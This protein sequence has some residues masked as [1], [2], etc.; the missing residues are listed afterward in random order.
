MIKNVVFTN[1][2]FMI[3]NDKTNEKN[4]GFRESNTGF[5]FPR[6]SGARLRTVARQLTVERGTGDANI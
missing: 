3:D 5:S 4:E 6:F 2:G 1:G